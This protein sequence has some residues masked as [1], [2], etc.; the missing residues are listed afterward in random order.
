MTWDLEQALNHAIDNYGVA[1]SVQ[2]MHIL[3]LCEGEMYKEEYVK[4][5]CVNVNNDVRLSIMRTGG[6]R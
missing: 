1:V 3:A 6:V 2:V 4:R 5:L